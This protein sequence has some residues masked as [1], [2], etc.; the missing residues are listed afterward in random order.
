MQA[1]AGADRRAGAGGHRRGDRDPERCARRR[2]PHQGRDRAGRRRPLQ[3]AARRAGGGRRGASR[4][5]STAWPR[6]TWLAWRPRSTS[7][8][9]VRAERKTLLRLPNIRGGAEVLDAAHELGGQA[10]E[11]ATG[12]LAATFEAL[13]ARRCRR[14]HPP[15]PGPASRP[16]LLHGCDRRGLRPRPGPRA[17]RRRPLRRGDGPVR[18]PAAGGRVRALP[19]AAAHRAGRRGA[20][21]GGATDEPPVEAGGAARRSAGGHARPPRP[22]G[23]RHRRGPQ[24]LARAD[25]RRGRSEVGDDAPLRRPHLRRGRRRRHRHHRQGRAAR[26]DTTESSTSSSTFATASAGWSW[27]A[28]AATIAWPRR[29][30]AWARCGSRPSTRASPSAT[31]RTPAAG[32]R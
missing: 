29:S 17:G 27:P 2:R 26:A 20:S 22:R 11:R 32:R 9:S 8:S 13:R 16:R 25:L 15:G 23:R 18:P 30:G 21:P 10:V 31:S 6:T 12:R 28:A 24:R 7:W 5:W 3:A 1:G 4:A 19:G 14:P